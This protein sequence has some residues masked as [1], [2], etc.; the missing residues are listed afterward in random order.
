MENWVTKKKSINN[1]VQFYSGILQENYVGNFRKKKSINLSM[2]LA[3]L[4]EFNRVII[5]V[6]FRLHYINTISI[7]D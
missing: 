7:L 3:F 6:E 5:S 2:I 4:V 1:L